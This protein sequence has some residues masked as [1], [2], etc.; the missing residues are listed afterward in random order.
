MYIDFSDSTRV[1]DTPKS[2][3]RGF[4]WYLS[5]YINFIAATNEA[6]VN[7]YLFLFDEPGVHLH[8]SG[9]KDLTQL[10][11]E[12]CTKNQLIYTTHSPFMINREYPDRVRVVDKDHEGTKIDNEAYRENWRPLRQ[13]VGL[14]V[15]DLF[16]FSNKSI[17]VDLPQKKHSRLKRS[18]KKEQSK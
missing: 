11:E 7:E 1:Y 3:S 16:F 4:L 6:R 13:S 12:L 8:P 5:F 10:F 14:T 15:G 17:V 2:R 9:Q 18:N